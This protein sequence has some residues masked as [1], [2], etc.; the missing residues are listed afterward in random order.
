M[1]AR[2]RARTRESRAAAHRRPTSSARDNDEKPAA[3]VVVHEPEV[4]PEAPT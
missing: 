3:G 4:E 2:A 1:A